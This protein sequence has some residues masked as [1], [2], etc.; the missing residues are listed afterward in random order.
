MIIEENPT[1]AKVDAFAAR[2]LSRVVPLTLG[3]AHSTGEFEAVYR[4][5]YA[6][7]MDQGWARP[8][9]LPDG[10]ER[11]AFDDR[12]VQIVAWDNNKDVGTT[13]LVAPAAGWLLAMEHAF[14]LR[15]GDGGRVIDMGRTCRVPGQKD[16]GQRIIWGLLAKSWIELRC[17]GFAE[18]CGIFSLGM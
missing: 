9:D 3:V 16:I 11:D 8:A 17:R 1:L 18:V 12:A 13:R 5:R 15:I 2:M 10:L 14:D 4:L 6:V 7:V